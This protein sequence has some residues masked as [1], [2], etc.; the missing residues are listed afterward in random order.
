MN[1]MGLKIFGVGIYLAM[2]GVVIIGTYTLQ[3]GAMDD[4]LRIL[5]FGTSGCIILALVGAMISI[6][7][8]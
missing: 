3:M 2:I 8:D 1:G 4:I 5:V 7:Q 6:F